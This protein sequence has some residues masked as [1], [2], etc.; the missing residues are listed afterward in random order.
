MIKQ[1]HTF[2]TLVV[3]NSTFEEIKCLLLDAKYDHAF[4]DDGDDQ[5]I[6]MNGIGLKRLYDMAVISR[7][8][9]NI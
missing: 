8:K 5:I 1:T 4:I 6:D 3:S 2:A 9:G 7:N